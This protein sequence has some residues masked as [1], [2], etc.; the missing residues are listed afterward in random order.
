MRKLIFIMV[1]FI[2]ICSIFIVNA[3]TDTLD[4]TQWVASEISFSSTKDYYVPF[5][6]IDFDVIFTHKETGTE[7]KVPG[8]WDGGKIFKVRFALTKTG[9]WSY[10]TVCSDTANEGLHN[11]TGKINCVEYEGD[12]E[13]YKRGFVKTDPDLRYFIYDDGT[14]FFYLGDTHWFMGEEDIS[15]PEAMFYSIVDYRVNQKF[16]VYQSEP[17]GTPY[18]L[19][20][21]FSEFDLNGW[22]NL[23]IKFK[24][25]ADSGLVHANSQ[26][27]HVTELMKYYNA[28]YDDVYLDKLCRYWVAR[29]SAYPVLWTTAQESDNDF[30][31]ER[32]DSIFPAEENRWRKVAA[33]VYKYDPYKHP[34]TAHMEHT[35]FS[36]ASDSSFRDIEGHTWWGAQFSFQFD[37]HVPWDIVKDFWENGQGK[38]VVNY[39][40][41]YDHLWTKTFGS[42]AQGWIAYLN[43]MYGY[44]YGVQGI[45]D[46]WFND[47]DTYDGRDIISPSDK[48]V[49]WPEALKFPSGEQMTIMRDFFEEY[50]WWELKP[51][52]DDSKFISAKSKFRNKFGI[53]VNF[54]N[55]QYSLA[56]IDDDL[57]VLYLFN[58]SMFSATLKGLSTTEYT[59][60]WFNPRTG[61]YSGEKSVFIF[62]GHYQVGAKP[63]SDDWIL[64][65]EK[66]GLFSYYSVA[67]MLLVTVT[68]IIKAKRRKV[69][70]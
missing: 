64:V 50:D 42:R 66:T 23:D 13:I 19:S 1:I 37:T 69:K 61:E 67:S 28:I 6:D 62:T 24:Y 58:N 59:V 45:W 46:D 22:R 11:K 38:V 7:L 16:T 5:Y 3:D 18:N 63:D 53:V 9:E 39:E 4:A 41:K 65:M 68:L 48:R 2:I 51:R 30:Y 14:P 47:E 40:G 52:F 56:T 10:V 36:I 27:F 31:F 8:F 49:K 25:I 26:L 57:Y 12:L 21:G 55:H 70:V 35:S 60:K 15:S 43:G 29:Y 32:G 17:L 34:L 44:G 20:D 54:E 33:F